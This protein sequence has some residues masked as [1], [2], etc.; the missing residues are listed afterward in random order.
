[1]GVLRSFQA[2]QKT[3]AVAGA[4]RRRAVPRKP[5]LEV[6]EDRCLLS[7][8]PAHSFPGG[9][10]PQAIA[11]GDFA[12]DGITDL[13]MTNPS[14]TGAGSVTVLLGRGDGTFKD[15]TSFPVGVDPA[16]VAVADLLGNG[17]AD[18]IVTNRFSNT[19]SI[20]LGNG[21]GT[22]QA[23]LDFPTGGGPRGVAVGDFNNDGIPDLAV[24][25]SSGANAVDILLGNGDGTFQA[26]VA[27]AA[28]FAP[29]SVATADLNNDGNSDLVVANEL[30]KTVS[31]LLG[32]GDGSFQP[33]VNYDAGLGV[34]SEAV[35]VGDF[36]HDGAPD[37]A[38]AN[39]TDN[40]MANGN[41][42]VLLNNGDGT[43]Q[44]AINNRLGNPFFRNHPAS[45][46][47]SDLDNNGNLDLITANPDDNTASILKGR[48]DG[49][50]APDSFLADSG[51][52][53]GVAAGDFNGD[54]F[55]DLAMTI[56]TFHHVDVF[57]NAGDGRGPGNAAS[58]A[59]GLATA[60]PAAHLTADPP[61]AALPPPAAAL[62]PERLD[63]G[64]AAPRPAD[65]ASQSLALT[66]A[67]DPLPADAGLVEN[68]SGTFGEPR[69]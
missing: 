30:D 18:L 22:F 32:N 38:V 6:L 21:D 59:A 39:D 28:G 13:V 51:N 35:V 4:G 17:N 31:V 11:V 23:A 52:P 48:G 50:F 44:T 3:R 10:N 56:P 63:Q 61:V 65:T 37:I 43:F 69:P 60:A 26:P 45:L 41:V 27:Y 33:A 58:E 46:T 47:E 25:S 7:F 40:R 42:G 8:L 55:P 1:M 12:N 68:L 2:E 34:F 66:Y 49:T 36:N 5:S 19:V 53:A 14:G 57:L 64:E 54:G 15:P 9:Q 62:P 16:S 20:L 29:I 24:T 67:P